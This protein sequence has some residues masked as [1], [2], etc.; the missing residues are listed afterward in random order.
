MDDILLRAA[1]VAGV[2]LLA[3]AIA[4]WARR[5]PEHPIRAMDVP[6]L[7]GGVYLFTAAAC[8]TCEAARAALQERLGPDG[9]TEITWE[10]NRSVFSELRVD[11]V[12]AVLVVSDSGKGTLYPGRVDEALRQQSR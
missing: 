4:W 6:A 5:H 7:D 12:P 3:L 2:A 8:S 1:L 9:Y 10:D 11:A